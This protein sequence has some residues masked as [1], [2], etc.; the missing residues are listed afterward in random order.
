MEDQIEPMTTEAA[1]AE[2]HIR[3]LERTNARLDALNSR[4]EQ[5]QKELGGFK[6]TWQEG[7]RSCEALARASQR[8]A[9]F[10]ALA[11]LLVVVA[12]VGW[13]DGA[14]QPGRL[15]GI[16]PALSA[17]W[18]AVSAKIPTRPSAAPEN[19][20]MSADAVPDA[21]LQVLEDNPAVIAPLIAPPDAPATVEEPAAEVPGAPLAPVPPSTPQ[22]AGATESLTL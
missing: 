20:G 2:Q 4:L 14:W 3:L 7:I 13:M 18:S 8:F 21:A 5:L 19:S 11:T 9:R 22:D 17:I 16:S 10:T 15:S 6:Q 1:D 12:F